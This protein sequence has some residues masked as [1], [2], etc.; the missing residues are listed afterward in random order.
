MA[1]RLC[2]QLRDLIHATDPEIVETIK[3]TN[4]RAGGWRKLKSS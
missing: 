2:Q 3:R 1:G 4:N